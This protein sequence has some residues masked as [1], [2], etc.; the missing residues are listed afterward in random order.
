[1]SNKL[2]LIADTSV[3]SKKAYQYLSSFSQELT[4]VFWERHLPKSFNINEW[5]GDWIISFKSD[6]ILSKH[7]LNQANRGAINFHPAPPYYRGLGGYRYALLNG[8]EH[9]GCTCHHMDEKIDHGKI[10]NVNYFPIAKK[11]TEKS[12]CEKTGAY[13]LTQLYT[14]FSLITNNRSLPESSDQ[15]SSKLYTKDM[16]E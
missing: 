9:F 13:A 14:V 16:I 2:L 15:W 5:R 7:F 1:M 3:W 10:I 11:E 12:L 4:A 8:D 6:L